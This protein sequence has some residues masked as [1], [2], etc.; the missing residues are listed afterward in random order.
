[1][2]PVLEAVLVMVC[3][4]VPVRLDEMVPELLGVREGVVDG[5]ISVQKRRMRLLKLSLTKSDL[6]LSA[7]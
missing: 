2:V 5:E 6:V 4:W 1:M 3:E 7:S